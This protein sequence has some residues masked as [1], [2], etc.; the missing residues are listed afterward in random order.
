MVSLHPPEDAK[1]KWRLN[2]RLRDENLHRRDHRHR[3]IRT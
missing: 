2:F 1:N 3:Q